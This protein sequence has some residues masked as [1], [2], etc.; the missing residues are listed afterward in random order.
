MENNL[1]SPHCL[2]EDVRIVPI[3]ISELEFG[4]IEREILRADLV[5]GSNHAALNQGPEAFDRVCVNRANHVLPSEMVNG[6]VGILTADFPVT[7]PLVGTEHANFAGNGFPNEIAK[8]IG[9]D[10]ID[11]AGNHV[12]LAADGPN[13]GRL[14]GTDA[15]SSTGAALVP[16]FVLLFAADEGLIDF[17]NAHELLE[18][19]VCQS[20]PDTVAHIPSCLVGA[21]AHHAM[22]LKGADA[23]FAAK[24]QMDHAEPLPERFVGVLE[25]GPRNMGEPIVGARRGASVA[26]PVP[27]HRAM[28]FN[29]QIAATGAVNRV[30]P[31]MRHQVSAAG[32][33]VRECFFPFG[34]G[35]LGDLLGLFGA[36]HVGSPVYEENLA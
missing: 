7:T 23:L 33:F 13:Y 1:A 8:R 14:A 24:H 4:N 16:M 10:T 3:V 26:K 27:S 28:F 21:E 34:D 30:H 17:H 6:L 29:R 20:K 31:T 12:P 9:T 32:I 22:D 25:N 2:S 5:E 36:A 18:V 19:F 11:Y 35:H 15:A